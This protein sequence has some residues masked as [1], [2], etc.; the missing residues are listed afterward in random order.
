MSS[1]LS[2]LLPS[3]ASLR[4]TSVYS[5]NLSR[6]TINIA[7]LSD[8]SDSRFL[9]LII[10]TETFS[11]S[12]FLSTFFTTKLEPCLIFKYTS[13]VTFLLQVKR[14]FPATPHYVC[15]AS[16]HMIFTLGASLRT[17]DNKSSAMIIATAP[18]SA[19][20]SLSINPL[21][22]AVLN[23]AEWDDGSVWRKRPIVPSFFFT[24]SIRASWFFD[25]IPIRWLWFLCWQRDDRWC[26]VSFLLSLH[27]RL[28]HSGG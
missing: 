28:R 5:T 6:T 24:S 14:G 15:S 4:D 17:Y 1:E 26:G 18:W 8:P 25:S 22:G 19:I 23:R 10:G 12:T 9:Q 21:A 16:K 7:V 3:F 2:S 11:L 20:R 13:N 27:S